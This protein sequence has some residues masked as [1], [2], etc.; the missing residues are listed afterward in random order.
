MLYF[1]GFVKSTDYVMIMLAASATTKKRIPWIQ[2]S[3]LF[4]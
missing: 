1:M 2:K 4:S 3:S